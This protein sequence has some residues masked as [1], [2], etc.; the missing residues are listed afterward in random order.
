MNLRAA[1]SGLNTIQRFE[2]VALMAA[3]MALNALAI[4]TM[5]PALDRISRDTGAIDANEQQQ[6]IVVYLLGVGLPQL[7]IGPLTDRFG[8]RGPLALSLIFYALTSVACALTRDFT[9]LLFWRFFQGMAASGIRVCAVAVV[10]DQFAGRQMASTMSLIM[11]VF[12]IVPIIAPALG[13]GILLFA[14][15]PWIFAM[16]GIAGA[17]TLIWMLTRLPESLPRE[18]RRPLSV[19]AVS[20]AYRQVFVTPVTLGYMLAS[21]VVFSAL[22]AFI[23]AAPQILGEVYGLTG[24]FPIWFAGIAI[25]MAVSNFTNSRLVGRFGMRLISHIALMI[26]TGFSAIALALQVMGWSDIAVFYPLFVVIFAC[27]GLMGSNFNALAM[28]P[29]GAIA[30]TASAVY[31]FFTTTLSALVGGFIA[32]QFDGTAAPLMAGYLALGLTTMVILLIVEKGR[33]F[34]SR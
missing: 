8:R 32:D 6:I 4:D 1:F 23:A 30:G 25:M 9:A 7:V 15:W 19:K 22:F 13:Q 34:K 31:G 33:L 12:M 27:F 20:S 21:G 5:L 14:P 10:R 26:F 17:T 28:E 18:R 11:T 2:F 3:L 24:S 16:L 29:L